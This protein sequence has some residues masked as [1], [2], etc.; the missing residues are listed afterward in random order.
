MPNHTTTKIVGTMLLIA[1]GCFAS[2]YALPPDALHI[3]IAA[4]WFFIGFVVCK[5]WRREGRGR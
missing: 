5:I 4:M 1:F 2:G 3:L